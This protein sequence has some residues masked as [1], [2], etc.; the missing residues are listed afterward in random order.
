LHR[1]AL[2]AIGVVLFVL[3]IIINSIAMIVMRRGAHAQNV[4]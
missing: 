2:F 3:I 4:R 1:S